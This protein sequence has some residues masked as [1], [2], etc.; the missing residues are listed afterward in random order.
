MHRR[1]NSRQRVP[2][3]VGP[4]ELLE[5]RVM[6]WACEALDPGLAVS[7]VTALASSP[8]AAPGTIGFGPGLPTRP[9]AAWTTGDKRILYVR[10]TF[11]DRPTH[12]PQ[13]LDSARRAMDFADQFV[14]AN[15]YGQTSFSTEFTDVVV[16]P[17][18]ESYYRSVGW[19]RL[20]L[21]A[22]SAAGAMQYDWDSSF[23]NLDVIRYDG[24]P[25]PAGHAASGFANTNNRGAWL[26][27]DAPNL[28]MHELGH[29]LGLNHANLWQGNDPDAPDGPGRHFE[30]GN[31]FDV[32]GTGGSA[33]LSAHFNA[34]EKHF[35]HWLPDD[36]VATIE[37]S[38]TYTIYPADNPGPTQTG[39]LYALKVRKDD[40]RDYWLSSRAD[41]QWAAD[42]SLDGLEVNWGA[43]SK[44]GDNHS[45]L[46]SHLLDMTP[47]TQADAFDYGLPLGRTFTDEVAGVHITPLQRR[48]AGAVDI[49]V[50]FDDDQPAPNRN[51]PTPPTISVAGASR[52]AD[53]DEAI[54]P[55][56]VFT[57]P[58]GQTFSLTASSSD[59][60]GDDLAYAWD[61][62]KGA[63]GGAIGPGGV[64]EHAGS[65]AASVTPAVTARYDTPGTYRVQVTLSDLRGR[66]MS[67]SVVVRVTGATVAPP[68]SAITGRVLDTF[69]RPMNRVRVG[70]GSV[71]TYSDHDGTYVLPGVEASPRMLLASRPGGWAFEPVGFS[72]PLDPGPVTAGADFRAIQTGYRISGTVTTANSFSIPDALVSDGTQSTLTDSA[73]RFSLTVPNGRYALTF[74]KPGTSIPATQVVVDNSDATLEV[75][76]ESRPVYGYIRLAPG[77]RSVRVSSGD[78]TVTPRIDQ[79]SGDWFYWFDDLPGVWNLT[80]FAQDSQFRA[81]YF[82]PTGW[83]NPVPR[84]EVRDLDFTYDPSRLMLAGRVT[85]G[86]ASVPGAMVTVMDSASG[87]V[88]EAAVT[89]DAGRYAVLVPAASYFVSVRK[90]GWSITPLQLPV[91]LTDH[92]GGVDFR[93]VS[94]PNVP[95]RIVRPAYAQPSVVAGAST[96]LAT[97]ATDGVD[98]ARLAYSWRLLRGPPGGTVSFSR[99]GDNPAQGTLA[100]FNRAGVYQ[101]QSTVE[102]PSGGRSSSVATVTVVSV[103]SNVRVNPPYAVMP[104]GGTQSLGADLVDQFGRPVDGAPPI[105]WHLAGAVGT[106]DQDGTFTAVAGPPAGPLRGAVVAR[107]MLAGGRELLGSATVDVMPAATVVR[108]QVFY[109]NSAYD[110]R[111]PGAHASDDAAIAP[112]KRPFLP[113]QARATAA[114]YTGSEKGINGIMVD[115]DGAWGTAITAD[116]FEFAVGFGAGGRDWTA[117]P[118]PREVSIRTVAY[119]GRPV[120]RVTLVWDDGAVRNT[121]LRVTVLPT[122]RT[123]LATPDVFY[124]GNLAGDTGDAAPGAATARVTALDVAAALRRRR[125]PG[126]LASPFDH[127]HDGVVTEADAHVSRRNQASWIELI[128]DNNGPARAAGAQSQKGSAPSVPRRRSRY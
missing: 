115:I 123:G 104:A 56:P 35:L 6:C 3:T 51:A 73:G 71:W 62:G 29:N 31:P 63:A 112:D 79:A 78:R 83:S 87:E 34:Y 119:Q 117:A 81:V 38:G 42:R 37:R 22:L 68:R 69:G 77:M 85:S 10:A 58:G 8:V 108:R 76:S 55:L 26:R 91:I 102:D 24:G 105:T 75:R 97:Y 28:A 21:D 27:D 59:A 11:S 5:R 126:D 103:P 30:Y 125:T 100:T 53:E 110:G 9:T 116:D 50:Q 122:V 89:D 40:F 74:T 127:D 109:N 52:G 90:P 92:K 121:W 49:A 111:T 15:S 95:P 80:A 86:V 43:W 113:G 41:A 19:D 94:A 118:R 36:A 44:D 120:R 25:A 17:H 60:D 128:L 64:V 12:E 61:F 99:N 2:R 93:A 23:F 65:G 1:L 70:D 7:D 13:T 106:V 39:R 47:G 66:A 96:F 32:M 18:P 48:G 14:R 67:S 72:N 45:A 46:G 101:I 124:F 84:N 107:V 98:T 20:R 82:S 4:P 54:F 33:G 16:L 88:V 57:T 114:N